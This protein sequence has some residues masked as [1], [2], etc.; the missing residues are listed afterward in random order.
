M[1]VNLFCWGEAQIAW[2][3]VI[4]HKEETALINKM[5]FYYAM[6]RETQ[7]VAAQQW[8]FV[9]KKWSGMERKKG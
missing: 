7:I 4:F 5:L 1:F 6:G 2:P 9:T 8:S 3:T